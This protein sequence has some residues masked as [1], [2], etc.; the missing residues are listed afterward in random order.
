MPLV[1]NWLSEWMNIVDVLMERTQEVD[2]EAARC[3]SAL[4][5][6]SCNQMIATHQQ[7][8]HFSALAIR[9]HCIVTDPTAAIDAIEMKVAQITDPGQLKLKSLL[10][11]GED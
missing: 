9:S 11:V 6:R 2:N 5:Y 1:S 7:A 10:L 8:D 4:F 3:M